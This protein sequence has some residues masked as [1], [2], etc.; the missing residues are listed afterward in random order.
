VR[1]KFRLVPTYR[2][3][4][5]EIRGVFGEGGR[6]REQKT[7]HIGKLNPV[8]YEPDTILHTFVVPWKGSRMTLPVRWI[9]TTQ[10]GL[11]SQLCKS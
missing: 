8:I 4:K 2:V 11:F 6:H 5:K 9:S 10:H 3:S 7:V 1:E